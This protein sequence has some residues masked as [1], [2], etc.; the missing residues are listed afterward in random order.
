[1]PSTFR[2]TSSGGG[3]SILSL[4][5]L[6]ADDSEGEYVSP[7][8]GWHR[9]SWRSSCHCSE[10]H[11]STVGSGCLHAGVAMRHV[12]PEWYRRMTCSSCWSSGVDSGFSR[13]WVRA[14]TLHFL[15][16]HRRTPS[17]GTVTSWAS[18]AWIGYLAQPGPGSITTMQWR[19]AM[20]ASSLPRRYGIRRRRGTSSEPSRL[21][22]TRT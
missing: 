20:P 22:R 12:C 17:C 11:C 15:I 10:V 19:T 13:R 7:V 8:C 18:Q 6:F 4:A 3:A 16:R 2:F 14:A 5:V 1:M 9:S 21:M